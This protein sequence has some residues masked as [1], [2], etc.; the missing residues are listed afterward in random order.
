MAKS[1]LEVVN[2]AMYGNAFDGL[3]A[4]LE[5]MIALMWF[6]YV[7]GMLTNMIVAAKFERKTWAYF[8]NPI[9]IV[10]AIQLVTFALIGALWMAIVNDPARSD[11]VVTRDVIKDKSGGPPSFTS[12]VLLSQAY[13]IINGLNMLLTVVQLLS[14]FEVNYNL[15]MLTD[16]IGFMIGE[17]IQ[18]CVVLVTMIISFMLLSHIY[19][20]QYMKQFSTLDECFVNVFEY[21][22]SR[23]DFFILAEVSG[24]HYFFA[25]VLHVRRQRVTTP[26]FSSCLQMDF[27]A[28]YLFFVPFTFI[29]VFVVAN[30]VIA[31]ILDGYTLMQSKRETLA[32]SN[33]KVIVELTVTNQVLP[34][35]LKPLL[36]I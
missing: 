1:N 15:S 24:R 25:K 6:V 36:C 16:T 22:F 2:A 5:I 10:F 23:A 27:V 21:L 31:I 13:Y 28:A 26:H 3:R 32:S 11:L 12:T 35:H 33:I 34:L 18:F 7:F 8:N 19:F 14:F 20:G 30:I 9:H 17:L 29:M 4:A